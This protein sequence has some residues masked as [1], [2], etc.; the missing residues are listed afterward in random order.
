MYHIFFIHSCIS[1]HLA[2]SYIL[3]IINNA[4]MNIRVHVSFQISVFNFL[5]IYPGVEL[6][7]HAVVLFSVVWETSRLFST[8]V[9]QCTFPPIVC[10]GSLFCTSLPSL[11]F[12]VFF[13]HSYPYRCG[14]IPQCFFYFH[15]PVI[16]NI[17]HLFMYLLTIW[18]S[19]LEKFLFGFSRLENKVK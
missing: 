1:G 6:L 16:S 13:H 7:G 8:V 19:S 9:A 11:V 14:V 10:E 3:A 17:E 2:C 5:D 4:A 12:C 18:M 15:F